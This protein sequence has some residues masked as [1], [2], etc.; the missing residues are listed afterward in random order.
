MACKIE[1]ID[2]EDLKKKTVKDFMYEA[3]NIREIAKMRFDFYE[4]RWKELIQIVKNRREYLMACGGHPD[5]WT[6]YTELMK[7]YASVD[8]SVE[9]S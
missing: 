5:S 6:L 8:G 2:I 4:G 3:K 7:E 1:G 9:R